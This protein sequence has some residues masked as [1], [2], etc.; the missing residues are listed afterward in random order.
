LV[1]A[2]LGVPLNFTCQNMAVYAGKLYSH[3]WEIEI[4]SKCETD[5]SEDVM[6]TGDT[7]RG[8]FLEALGDPLD[9]GAQVVTIYGDKL[10][11]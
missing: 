3:L 9:R 1:H 8:G 6:G 7:V 2:A 4:G 11:R 5:T 10:H